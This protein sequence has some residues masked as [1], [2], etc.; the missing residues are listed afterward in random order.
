MLNSAV[1]YTKKP[2]LLLSVLYFLFHRQD[3]YLAIFS[4]V[5]DHIY[6]AP[7]LTVIHPTHSLGW[8]PA[9][10]G[11]SFFPPYYTQ[12]RSSETVGFEAR[13]KEEICMT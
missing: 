9:P 5:L 11:L 1:L 4:H 8:V 10:F 2:F 12:S 6:V 7:G 3:T 13:H